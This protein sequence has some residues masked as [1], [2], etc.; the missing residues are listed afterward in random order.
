MKQNKIYKYSVFFIIVYRRLA[1]CQWS[2]A[3]EEIHYQGFLRKI[4]QESAFLVVS[5]I[6]FCDTSGSLNIK[7]ILDHVS[8][9]LFWLFALGM[10]CEFCFFFLQPV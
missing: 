7:S 10:S 3:G 8:S 4:S 9:Q 2:L 6:F 5:L 1:K